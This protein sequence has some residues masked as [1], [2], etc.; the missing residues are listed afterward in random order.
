MTGRMPFIFTATIA[1]L[2]LQGTLAAGTIYRWTDRHGQ[3]HF[4]DTPPGGH[5]TAIPGIASETSPGPG[6]PG[7]R[8]GERRELDR[9]A[10]Q[11]AQRRLARQTRGRK[12]HQHREQTRQSCREMREH[13]RDTRDDVLRKHYAH[14]LRELCW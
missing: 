2:V 11:A 12:A 6:R 4:G 9:L 5:S 7:L 13:L 1:L 8:H 3:P 10:Q 14:K